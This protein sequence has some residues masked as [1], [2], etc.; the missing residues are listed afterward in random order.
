M[1]AEDVGTDTLGMRQRLGLAAIPEE[2]E[3]EMLREGDLRAGDHFHGLVEVPI[4]R[5]PGDSFAM[6][7]F[8]ASWDLP[9]MKCRRE[10]AFGRKEHTFAVKA[11]ATQG[12][13]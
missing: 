8:P 5:K 12:E 3:V 1:V 9:L 13:T 4:S 2:G 7:C 10:K 6:D 11:M